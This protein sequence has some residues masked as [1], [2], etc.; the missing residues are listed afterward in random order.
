MYL[1]VNCTVDVYHNFGSP[2]I[3][4]KCPLPNL[5]SQAIVFMRV[6]SIVCQV[7]NSLQQSNRE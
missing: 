7:N 4:G 2:N 5:S 1:Q 3:F 6:L